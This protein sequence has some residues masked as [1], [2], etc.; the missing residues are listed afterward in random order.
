[1]SPVRIALLFSSAAIALALVVS[2]YFGDV[3]PGRADLALNDMPPPGLDTMATGSTRTAGKS[4]IMRRS[5][6]QSSPNAVCII[7]ADGRRSGDC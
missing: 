2:S 4:Y 3:G 6:L 5:I 7:S 1:M